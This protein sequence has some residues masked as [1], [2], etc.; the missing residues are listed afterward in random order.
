MTPGWLV[1]IGADHRS[2]VV[3]RRLVVAMAHQVAQGPRVDGSRTELRGGTDDGAS[4]G[5]ITLRLR[6]S[7]ALA[8]GW[9]G[10]QVP[11][12]RTWP[13]GSTWRAKRALR[14]GGDLE[15]VRMVTGSE[16]EA[17]AADLV[18]RSRQQHPS[19]GPRAVP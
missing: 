14:R 6:G 2:V 19:N 3:A 9:R 10:A 7:T 12:P 17:L 16:G 8:I 11:D 18:A 4:F 13:G 15:L 5:G 1:N